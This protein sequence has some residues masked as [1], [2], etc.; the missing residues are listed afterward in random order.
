MKEW[1]REQKEEM[2]RNK[3]TQEGKEEMKDK[4]NRKRGIGRNRKMTKRRDEEEE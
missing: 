3:D 1:K 2:K 4:R